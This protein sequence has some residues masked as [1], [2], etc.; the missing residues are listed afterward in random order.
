MAGFFLIGVP[1]VLG[2]AGGTVAQFV[3]RRAGVPLSGRVACETALVGLGVLGIT[4]SLPA[5]P[6]LAKTGT[7]G[8]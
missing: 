7:N 1:L 3:L 5:A 4:H 8:L 2:C 6:T